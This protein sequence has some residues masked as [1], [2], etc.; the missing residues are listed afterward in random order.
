MDNP[1]QPQTL[2]ASLKARIA[3]I[4]AGLQDVT[5]SERDEMRALLMA[6][7]KVYVSGA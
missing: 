6:V 1:E 4:R 3:A 7:Q 2:Q 5:P